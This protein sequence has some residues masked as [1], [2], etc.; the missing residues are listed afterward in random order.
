MRSSD[1]RDIYFHINNAK[2]SIFAVLKIQGYQNGTIISS[3]IFQIILL[4]TT[5]LLIGFIFN[6]IAV[7][8]LSGV[9]PVLINYQIITYV[10]AAI[11]AMSLLGAVFSAYSVLKIDP[12]DSL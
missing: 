11:I 5:G 4:T 10:S 6:L 8:S 12:L 1:S 3:I 9:V 7:E 2:K